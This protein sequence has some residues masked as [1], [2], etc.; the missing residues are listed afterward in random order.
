[1]PLAFVIGRNKPF[2]PCFPLISCSV[3]YVIVHLIQLLNICI[4]TKLSLLILLCKFFWLGNKAMQLKMY[5]DAVE[6]YNCAIALC[7]KNAVYYCNRCI[8]DLYSNIIL[9][10]NELYE[11]LTLLYPVCAILKIS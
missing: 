1:M 5:S 10:F 3:N 8:I 11:S 6:F 4:Q 9:Y 2:L 7:E